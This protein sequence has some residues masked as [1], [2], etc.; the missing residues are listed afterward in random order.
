MKKVP[1]SSCAWEAHVRRMK[2]NTTKFQ[3]SNQPLGVNQLLGV[4]LNRWPT[5]FFLCK[6]LVFLSCAWWKS[7]FFHHFRVLSSFSTMQMH[8]QACLCWSKYTTHCCA[9]NAHMPYLGVFVHNSVLKSANTT[10][11]SSLASKI[12]QCI[13]RSNFKAEFFISTIDSIHGSLVP[14]HPEEVKIRTFL[15]LGCWQK[16]QVPHTAFLLS[17]TQRTDQIQLTIIGEN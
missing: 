10:S 1:F 3:M 5:N 14:H 9:K 8:A 6:P 2:K 11:C 16:I 13:M 4:T 15:V 12:Y 7:Y 17:G